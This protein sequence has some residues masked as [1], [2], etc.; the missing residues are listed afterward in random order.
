MDFLKLGQRG[1]DYFLGRPRIDVADSQEGYCWG[2]AQEGSQEG[3]V[4]AVLAQYVVWRMRINM[5]QRAQSERLGK[6]DHVRQRWTEPPG[7]RVRALRKGDGELFDSR[8]L[9]EKHVDH[10]RVDLMR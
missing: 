4:H 1:L 9:A 3:A 6:S 10:H 8:N 7:Y 5:S 2:V